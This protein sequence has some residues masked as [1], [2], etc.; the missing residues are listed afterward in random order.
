M[1][2]RVERVHEQIERMVTQMNKALG[3]DP[4]DYSRR[5]SFGYIGN[6]DP[7]GSNDDRAWYVFLPHPGRVGTDADCLG[8]GHRTDDYAGAVRTAAMVS[9]ALR[10]ARWR[11]E[12]P[13][14]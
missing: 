1:D 8:S 4:A 13:T 11:A 3:L 12:N 14:L 9:G 7:S 5:V 10:F 2:P 6:V